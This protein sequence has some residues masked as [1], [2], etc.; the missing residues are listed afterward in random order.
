MGPKV[1]IPASPVQIFNFFFTIEILEYIVQQTNLY[2]SECMG[3]VAF[4]LG[5][6]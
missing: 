4:D 3:A 2:A 5:S 1:L 6:H